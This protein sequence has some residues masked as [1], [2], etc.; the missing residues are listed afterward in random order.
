MKCSN[1]AKNDVRGLFFL[2]EILFT[3]SQSKQIKCPHINFKIGRAA[4]KILIY[5][6]YVMKVS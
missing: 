6:I 3:F 5:H 4:H 1:L 2:V